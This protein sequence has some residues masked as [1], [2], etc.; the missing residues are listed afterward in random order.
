MIKYYSKQYLVYAWYTAYSLYYV[1]IVVI[2]P[3]LL[4]TSDAADE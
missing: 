3:C 1:L 4:Y 2:C